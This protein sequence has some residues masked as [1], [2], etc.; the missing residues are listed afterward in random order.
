MATTY[1][2]RYST[3]QDKW[4]FWDDEI[5]QFNANPPKIYEGTVGPNL[6]VFNADTPY[7]GAS[8]GVGGE[9]A[10]V[11][12]ITSSLS[13]TVFI[14]DDLADEGTYNVLRFDDDIVLESMDYDRDVVEPDK[15]TFT[16]RL[17]ETATIQVVVSVISK[18]RFQFGLADSPLYTFTEFNARF[19]S[20]LYTPADAVITPPFTAFELLTST[21]ATLSPLAVGEALVATDADG[22]EITYSLAPEAPL[23]FA[24]TSE[25]QLT[26][27]GVA[28][29]LTQTYYIFDVVV[30]SIGADRTLTEVVQ[31][32]TVHV[33][34][35]FLEL[36]TDE[37][38]VLDFSAR[39]APLVVEAGD[40]SDTIKLGSGDDVVTP[41]P[42]NDKVDL[43]AGGKDEV[44]VV[45]SLTGTL[46]DGGDIITGF[47]VKEDVLH[48]V[49]RIGDEGMSAIDF[50]QA[51]KGPN[52]IAMD[53]D[54]ILVVSPALVYDEARVG[55]VT[56]VDFHF[57][58][59]STFA[60]GMGLG[61]GVMRI[62]FATPMSPDAF[63]E[64][65]GGIENFHSGRF[66]II[67][68]TI[69]IPG[70][71]GAGGFVYGS[72]VAEY[73]AVFDAIS[74]NLALRVNDDGSTTPLA[75]GDPIA[76]SDANGDAITYSLSGSP[77]DYQIDA[78]TGQISY[79]GD[80]VAEDEFGTTTSLIVLA[81]STG[82]SGEAFSVP[83]VVVVEVLDVIRPL[84]INSDMTVAP[85]AAA[86][87][88]GE[89]LKYWDVSQVTRFFRTFKDAIE[90]NQ[91]ING[92]ML[93]MRTTCKVCF[94]RRKPLINTLAAGM[95]AA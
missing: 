55:S 38:E 75:L 51:A 83:Q 63:L 87:A 1:E 88:A 32:V 45:V 10:D 69:A 44:R 36:G 25:G 30:T 71:F 65:I 43:S 74:D 89:D 3:E 56:G 31:S 66:S 4:Q 81:T 37:G 72:V 15:I 23:G 29:E 17:S 57:A 5:G 16:V 2:I 59:S 7:T 35:G 39:Q 70:L 95:L 6:I 19:A 41:G 79:V 48:F 11:Y 76:A 26:F 86:L 58:S 90:F 42:G 47:T 80:K 82:R 53:F 40:G 85:I 77:V 92:W 52:G 34:S 73:D 78:T 28:S 13:Q 9:G 22:D 50:L 62:E 60:D 68:L 33:V 8:V 12:R 91:E 18:L 14:A 64:A 93:A 94:L 27:T 49:P 46:V 24:I 54:D 20:F 21:V 84:K 67:D 61:S